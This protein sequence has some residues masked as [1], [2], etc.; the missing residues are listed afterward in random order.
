MALIAAQQAVVAGAVLTYGAVAAS[1]TI[2]AQGGP[3]ILL[4]K[5]DSATPDTVTIVIPGTT[6]FG[7]AE[8]DQVVSVAAG[9]E[10][11]ILVS[12]DAQDPTTGLIT[13]TH[14]QVATVT[15]AVLRT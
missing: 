2:N 7:A 1:D 14:S 15:C 13:V 6:P 8:P 12:S 10:K 11:A 4:V 9:A 3:F 5:N